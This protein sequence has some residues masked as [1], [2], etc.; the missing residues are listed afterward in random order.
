MADEAAAPPLEPVDAAPIGDGGGA[1]AGAQA[2]EGHVDGGAGAEAGAAAAGGASGEA[3]YT[4]MPGACC[5]CGQP[6]T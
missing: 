6:R 1:D 4:D 2:G 3:V 5:D